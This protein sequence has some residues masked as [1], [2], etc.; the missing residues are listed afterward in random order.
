MLVKLAKAV[1][2]MAKKPE[3]DPLNWMSWWYTHDVRDD[4]TK[5][6]EITRVFGNLPPQ[7]SEVAE[8]TWA[9]CQPHHE[10][11]IEDLFLPWHRYFVYSFERVVRTVISDPTFTLPY[12]NYIDVSSRA[13]PPEFLKPGDSVFKALF[14]PD[15]RPQVNQGSAID[16]GLPV[17]PINLDDLKYDDY[18]TF[19]GSLDNRLHGTVHVRVGNGIGMGSV[20]WAANDPVFWLHHCNI[21]RLWASWNKGGG[22]NLDSQEFLN[23]SFIFVGPDSRLTSFKVSDGL[24]TSQLDY[25]YAGLEKRPP[26]SVADTVAS[27]SSAGV[28]KRV[29]TNIKLGAATTTVT[30]KSE[31]DSAAI[32]T[33][34]GAAMDARSIGLVFRGLQT[35]V[36]PESL[37]HV[38]L[39]LPASPT[40]AQEKRHFAGTINF[41]EAQT[42]FDRNRGFVVD[43][44]NLRD[45]LKESAEPTITISPTDTPSADAKPVIGEISLAALK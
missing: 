24:S 23:Q 31:S 8:Q 27:F 17:S 21:D 26:S 39:N 5:A 1:D 3:Q 43:L 7:S 37:Y 25:Q 40:S 19:C 45:V 6:S 32:A 11:D 35:N 10:G 16:A 30:L 33:F 42:H 20:P 14:R 34:S 4:R 38:F 12:W 29:A 9:T 28:P 13:L 36:P 18:S 2:A 44:S 22:R 15:R 41:F